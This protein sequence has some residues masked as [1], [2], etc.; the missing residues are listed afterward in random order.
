M[1]SHLS[2]RHS[3]SY[4]EFEIDDTEITHIS[5]AEFD[6]L[7]Q[8]LQLQLNT[9][10]NADAF[11]PI[12]RQLRTHL[13]PTDE[14]RLIVAAAD[15]KLLRLPWCLWEFFSDYPKAEVALSPPE[16]T[17]SLQVSSTRPRGKVRILGILGN[18]QGIN[19]AQD[20]QLLQQLPNT[21]I[22]FL[23][24]PKA[25]EL[26]QQLW[27]PGWDMLFF[28]GH[29]SS[30]KGKGCIHLNP[31]ES[32]TIEELKYGLRTAI[33]HGLKLAIFNS[34]DGLGLAQALA[35]LHLP[36]V[37]VM[38][39]PV[40]DLVAQEF[41]KHFLAA[42]TQ[43]QS[44][45][46]AV[47]QAREQ[48]QALE[49]KFPCATWL[50]V[51]CQ[52]PAELPPTWQEWCG[53]PPVPLRL[54]TRG[55][56]KMMLLTSIAV[57]TFIFGIRW[58]SWLQPLELWAFDR[59]MQLR[60]TESPDSRLLVIT[61]SEQDIQ[62]QGDELRHGSL[63]E[64]TLNQL[65]E[66]LEK[67]QPRVI[68]LDLYRDFPA[69]ESVLRNHL[70]QND[71]LIAICKRPAPP[72]DPS[73]ILPP[74]ELSEDRLGFSDF[75]QDSDGAIRRQL[76]FMSPNPTSRCTTAY[77]FSLQ[78]AFRY[79]EARGVTPKFTPSGNLQLGG[80]V[81][82][83][84]ASRSEGYQPVDARGNQIL[85]NY[86]ASPSPQAIAQQVSLTQ[87][88]TGQINPNA[89]KNRIILIGTIAPSSGD[90]WYTPYGTEFSRKLPG[91]F[92]HAQMISQVLSAVLDHRP[93][94]WV[95]VHWGDT[96]WIGVWSL[97]GG[98]IGWRFHG[99]L[100]LGLALSAASGTLTGLCLLLLL[101]GGW[102]PLVPAI[103]SLLI[104][105]SSIASILDQRND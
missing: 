55:E 50:P 40:P 10:L 80:V 86:R 23:V 3:I 103:A 79:L 100:S 65:L 12:D 85:L 46:L 95:W 66:K 54:P 71:H 60:T 87:V 96:L 99:F 22:K 34:C 101:Q 90:Y 91:V 76:L 43:G 38:R 24:E 33:A 47:R 39:E 56:L 78:L 72:D 68:G 105:G 53:T 70:R 58:L 52:N 30:S 19:I 62:S 35:D 89:I 15:P 26:N 9:W 74:P 37:I 67:A 64:V 104:T 49:S 28:A 44:L 13:K 1:Y 18:S 94:L 6:Q 82:D 51:I 41:L 98:I 29:S 16:Y 97:A 57:T 75:V 84:L 27:Q 81:F 21:E 77:A 88:L 11:R 32:L 61:I 42:F 59:L 45:Y 25:Q 14:F 92:I 17:R 73:G 20:Q 31:T 102:I 48:L 4:P 5:Q 63:G 7:C 93:L 36:Q 69:S 83:Q 8:K 2:W